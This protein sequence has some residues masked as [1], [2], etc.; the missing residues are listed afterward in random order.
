MITHARLT[1]VLRYEPA[2][3]E[4]WWLRRLSPS[5]K[6]DRP[7]GRRTARGYVEIRV[8][9]RAYRAS[10]LAWFYV[11]RRWPSDYVDHVNGCTRDD[12]LANL[13]EATPTQNVLN[14]KYKKAAL[15]RD[16][17]FARLS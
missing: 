9:G 8:D 15:E 6:F 2:T 7:A 14:T 13:R 10:R 1:E 4:V 11:H 16:R 17:A 3:G 12:R 5:A